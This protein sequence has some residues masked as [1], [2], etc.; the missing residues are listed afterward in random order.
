M[1][2]LLNDSSYRKRTFSQGGISA[3]IPSANNWSRAAPGSFNRIQVRGSK[4]GKEVTKLAKWKERTPSKSAYQGT[5]QM[6]LRIPVRLRERLDEFLQYM[7]LDLR[8]RA[9]R[10][11]DWPS[12]LTDL[13]VQALNDFLATHEK[14][15]RTGPKPKAP[16]PI[17]PKPHTKGG[18]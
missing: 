5:V 9:P 4:F 13:T 15:V 3:I 17:T 10:T 12:T 18:E 6:N 16:E 1:R 7:E 11:E 8:Q 14:E 2:R